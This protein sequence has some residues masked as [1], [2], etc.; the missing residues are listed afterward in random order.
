MVQIGRKNDKKAV[1]YLL[2]QKS[3]AATVLYSYDKYSGDGI[4]L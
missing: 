2:K 4:K 1:E 3:P